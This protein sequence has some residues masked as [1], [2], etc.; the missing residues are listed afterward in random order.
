MEVFIPTNYST[1][2]GRVILIK[3]FTKLR[4]IKIVELWRTVLEK[5]EIIEDYMLNS[6]HMSLTFVINNPDNSQRLYYYALF[7]S[8]IEV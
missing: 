4:Y 2:L 8:N 3:P 1:F 6:K 7:L 5:S